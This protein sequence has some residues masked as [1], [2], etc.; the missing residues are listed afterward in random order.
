MVFILGNNLLI[1]RNYFWVMNWSYIAA[2]FDA[3]GCANIGFQH[4]GPYWTVTPSIIFSVSDNL[5]EDLK[6]FLGRERVNARVSSARASSIFSE[7]KNTFKVSITNWDGCRKIC[8]YIRDEVIEK[9][10]VIELMMDAIRLHDK[11]RK[12]WMRGKLFTVNDLREF[13]RIRHEI[14]KHSRKGPKKLKEY[15]SERS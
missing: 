13:D 10:Q 8:S 7:A 5:A 14:H 4:R 9:K 2:L 11:R 15:F 1:I 12:K 6:S 3:K